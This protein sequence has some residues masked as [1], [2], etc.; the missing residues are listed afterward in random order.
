MN[1]SAEFLPNIVKVDSSGGCSLTSASFT[2]MSPNEFQALSGKETN[3]AQVIAG[4]AEAKALG[5]KERGLSMLLKSSIKGIKP[6]LNNTTFSEQSIIMPYIQRPQRRH[7]NADYFRIT[8]GVQ[9]PGRGAGGIPS[10]AVDFTVQLSGNSV[11]ESPIKNIERY[12]LP[13]FTIFVLTWDDATNRTSK[14]YQYRIHAAANVDADNATITVVPLGKTPAPS[15][16]GNIP[17]F[18]TVQIGANNISDW[19]YHCQNQPTNNNRGLISNWFQTSRTSR[20]VS[21]VYKETLAKVM[22]GKLNAWDQHFNYLSLADQN[23][24]QAML[25][26]EAWLKAVFFND[27]ISDKQAVETYD[28]LETVEDPEQAGCVMEYK[29]NALGIMTML[30][31]NNRILDMNGGAID[32]ED[33]FEQVYYLK[34]YLKQ[35]ATAFLSST[36]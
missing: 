7:L 18:G 34:K 17:D 2:G 16:T 24:Q 23:K 27:Y 15:T 1:L 19:E 13:D 20:C 31:E 36:A 32:M 22:S 25:D 12:F 33:L 6:P 11:W 21:E 5:V 35:T 14:T 28:Q 8:A 4:T 30:G 3:L 29:A 10:D 9:T 26:D